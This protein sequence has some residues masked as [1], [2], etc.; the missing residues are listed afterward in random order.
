MLTPMLTASKL[1]LMSQTINGSASE[2]AE[3]LLAECVDGRIKINCR[4][5]DYLFT[6]V[7]VLKYTTSKNIYS[8]MTTWLIDMFTRATLGVQIKDAKNPSNDF[9][10]AF[11]KFMG[12]ETHFDWIYSLSRKFCT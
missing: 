7:V 4:R 11:R 2:F 3:D 1:K 6:S 9:A 12:E 10:V 8:R 5:F